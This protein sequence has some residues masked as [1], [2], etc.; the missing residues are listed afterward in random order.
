MTQRKTK[1]AQKSQFL[2]GG[3]LTTVLGKC[4]SRVMTSGSDKTQGRWS[5]VRFQG[6]KL[7]GGRE[8]NIWIINIYRVCQK[9]VTDSS[10]KLYMQPYNIQL[11]EGNTTTFPH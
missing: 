7:K 4:K 11:K 2:P 10:Y 1:Q 9:N 5:W 6:K 3:T 8:R